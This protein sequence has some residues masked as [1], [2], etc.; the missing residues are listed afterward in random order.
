MTGNSDA[1]DLGTPLRHSGA[2]T[3]ELR[4]GVHW[5][6]GGGRAGD[7]A[8][9]GTLLRRPRGVRDGTLQKHH[10]TRPQRTGPRA[11]RSPRL[12]HTTWSHSWCFSQRAARPR[13]SPQR[14]PGGAEGAA[15]STA[16]GPPSGLVAD[17]PGAGA[18][19]ACLLPGDR[20]VEMGTGLLGARGQRWATQTRT[21][22]CSWWQCIPCVTCEVTQSHTHVQGQGGHVGRGA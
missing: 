13:R 12:S 10:L 6:G 3:A 5:L 1:A 9:A 21:C 14:L 18:M 19:R 20:T 4:A 16:A 15:G 8:V 7:H 22:R 11:G 2:G 17:P